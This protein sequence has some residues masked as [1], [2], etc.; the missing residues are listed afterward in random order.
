M[1]ISWCPG[2]IETGRPCLGGFC[3]RALKM[4]GKQ[5]MA[6]VRP[7]EP[8]RRKRDVVQLFTA[9]IA[10]KKLTR[11][12]DGIEVLAPGSGV[13]E[14][15]TVQD[16]NGASMWVA[17]YCGE[18]PLDQLLDRQPLWDEGMA[19]EQV[20]LELELLELRLKDE[21]PARRVW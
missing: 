15:H 5:T 20:R 10:R 6:L 14:I 12:S 13:Y 17:L 7:V 3:P 11:P 21:K 16:E 1:I 19:N 9:E 8:G 2:D 4:R 18:R